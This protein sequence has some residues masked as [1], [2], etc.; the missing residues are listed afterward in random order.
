MDE[1]EQRRVVEHATR[2]GKEIVADL[3]ETIFARAKE[4]N[5]H[6]AVVLKS[7]CATLMAAGYSN[8]TAQEEPT[9]GA[10]WLKLLSNDFEMTMELMDQGEYKMKITCEQVPLFPKE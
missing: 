2:V 7:I 9:A 8:Y 3:V 10:C 4:R 6:S 1:K 5:A